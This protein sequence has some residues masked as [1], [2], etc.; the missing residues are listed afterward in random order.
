M[1]LLEWFGERRNPGPVGSL[2][3]REDGPEAGDPL[4]RARGAVGAA[5]LGVVLYALY[6]AATSIEHGLTLLAILAVY[7]GVASRLDPQPDSSNMGWAGGLIDHP[8]RWSD[9]ANRFLLL[10]RVVLFPGRFITA[11][12]RDG[13]RCF[14]PGRIVVR[15]RRPRPLGS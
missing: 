15:K 7:L 2:E 13:I 3:I 9:D 12:I 5:L 4:P 8:F 10:L 1:S 6:D 11:G 14:Q